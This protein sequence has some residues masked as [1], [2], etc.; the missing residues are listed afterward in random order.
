MIFKVPQFIEVE[1]KIFG[2]F[3]FKQFIYLVGGAGACFVLWN[4]LPKFVAVLLII[5]IGALALALAF[6]KVNKRP[7]VVILESFFRY[8]IGGKLYVWKKKKVK[9]KTEAE[10]DEI[11]IKE[12]KQLSVPTLSSNRLK[13]LAWSLDIHDKPH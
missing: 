9:K 6:W 11:D 2:P 7:F 12:Y 10:E 4:L 8:A 3:T 13:D 5:P 1:D